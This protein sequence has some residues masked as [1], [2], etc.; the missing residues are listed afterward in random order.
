MTIDIQ[1]RAFSSP[2]RAA[3]SRARFPRFGQDFTDLMVHIHHSDDR[4][5]YRAEILPYGP[6]LL[7]PA[8]K[9]LHYG[10]EIFEG[11]KAY[12]WPD[13]RVAM[14]R[15]DCNARRMNRSAHKMG[16]PQLPEPLHLA[17]TER[18]VDAV[19]D[20][21]P[22]M[23]GSSLYLRP[24]LLATEA[25]LGI[26]PA[27]EHLFFVIAGPAGPYFAGGF[28]S[29][30]VNVER[31]LI[32]AAAGGVGDAKTGGNYAAGM[33]AKARAKAAGCDDVL[34]LDALQHTYLEELSGMN[35][36]VVDDGRLLTPPLSG[37]I[38]PGIT[39]QSLIEL[40]PDLGLDV[41]ERP[42]AIDDLLARIRRGQVTEMMAVGTAAVVTPIGAL[43]DGGERV[44]LGDG[45][46]GPVTRRL[47]DTITGIQFGR[48]PDPYGWMRVVGPCGSVR[49][50]I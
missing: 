40:A 24:T 29:I 48:L 25:A 23:P 42:L 30:A 38:L 7:S 49:E 19:R 13:G 26:T 8:A 50:A 41:E 43:H 27:T 20:W 11:H 3:E 18:L 4:G 9:A 14:F 15:P 28:A 34:F 12:R 2:Q 31:G 35:V 10:L 37:T 39:R 32:R 17:A 33:A 45:E 44:V 21:V 36:F 16:L 47:Y 6:L 1:M 22:D 46:P 5:W